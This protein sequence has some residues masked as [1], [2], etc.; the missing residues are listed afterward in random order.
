MTDVLQEVT[1]E[2]LTREHVIRRVEDW[3]LRVEALYE[4]VTG[5]LP[6]G[7]T[8][9]RG[10]IVRMEEELMREF[11]VPARDVPILELWRNGTCEA[12]LEP[13]GLW[14][15]GANGRVDLVRGEAHYIITDVAENFDPPKWRIAPFSS[16]REL[17][18]L[19]AA[20]VQA[21]LS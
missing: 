9:R 4:L 15:I 1:D 2:H 11:G 21:L 20:H 17:E 3:S 16:R 14:I 18:P 8:A 5:W 10:R 6:P 13:R 19:D 12:I 7:W